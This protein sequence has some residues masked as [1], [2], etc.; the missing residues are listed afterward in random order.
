M[1]CEGQSLK[2]REVLKRFLEEIS[3]ASILQRKL[4][5]EREILKFNSHCWDLSALRHLFLL[6]I[7]KAASSMGEGMMDLLRPNF[8][9]SL[10]G[11]A[12]TKYQHGLSVAGMKTL[13]AAH[14]FPD[15][16]SQA[17]A[18]KVRDAL[19]DLPEQ[20]CGVLVLLSG[21]GSS[22]L[23]E[24]VDGLSLEEKSDLHFSLVRSGAPIDHINQVRAA[25]S[26][27]KGGGLVPLLGEREAL[28]LVLSDVIGNDLSM[29]SSGP[30]YPPQ[31]K[32]SISE[33]LNRYSIQLPAHIRQRAISDSFVQPQ[34]EIPHLL[35]ADL[36]HG[37]G[38]LE[39][40]F[41]GFGR[42]E[43][44][45]EPLVANLEDSAQILTER[46]LNH[47]CP[48]LLGGGE[49]TLQIHGTGKG[50][51]NMHFTCQAALNLLEKGH[52]NFVVFSIGTDGT[53]GPTDAAGGII[54]GREIKAQQIDE[55][56]VALDQQNTYPFLESIGGLL[57]TGPTGTNLNDIHGI[58]SDP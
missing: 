58:I 41:Q 3:G 28:V 11:L 16:N 30:F 1:I 13:E 5:I 44:L 43:V 53:D 26:K 57:K 10:H 45:R 22:L 52:R 29:V 36:S 47:Q 4:R 12:V 35:L 15:Q 37:L 24:P 14:P 19:L 9:G 31:K 50:G 7:G 54:H 56:R 6:S 8:H 49:S 17:A 48:V 20:S 46:F 18:A 55:L 25:F 27:I 23:C 39:D 21:G 33:I 38:I 32:I 2:I 34:R 42:V 51:R 40:L